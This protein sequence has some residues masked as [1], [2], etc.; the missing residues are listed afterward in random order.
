MEKKMGVCVENKAVAFFIIALLAALTFIVAKPFILAVVSSMVLAYAIHPFYIR[1]KKLLRNP[2]L[3]AAIISVIVILA[4]SLSVWFLMPMVIRQAFN[5]YMAVQKVD[6]AAPLRYIAPK[7]FTSPEFTRDFTVTVNQVISKV[8]SSTMNRFEDVIMNL[9]TLLIQ[10]IVM[11]FIFFFTLRNGEKIAGFMKSLSPLKESSERRFIQKFNDITK[12][13][14]YGMF[15]IG[16]LQGVLTGIGLYIFHVPQPLFLTVV[17]IFFGVLPYIGTWAVWIPISVALIISGNL[18]TAVA[19]G[20]YQLVAAG[21]IE[22]FIRPYV[23]KKGAKIPIAIALIGMLGGTYAF[24][25]IGL[26]IGPLILEYFILFLEF[27]RSKN[28]HELFS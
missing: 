5:S 8:A 28:L 22:F 6:F 9:P 19:F 14:V 11:L 15:I 2:S 4:I 17:A 1:L 24:G 26:V 13:I 12:S 3:T 27:Y 18:Q 10:F 25:V 20:A 23:V 7:F 16:I 21:L